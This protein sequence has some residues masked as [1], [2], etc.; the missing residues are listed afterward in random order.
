MAELTNILY[1]VKGSWTT[2]TL[3]EMRKYLWLSRKKRKQR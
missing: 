1:I 3:F 2:V